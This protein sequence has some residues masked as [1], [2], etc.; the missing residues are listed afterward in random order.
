VDITRRTAIGKA[1]ASLAATGRLLAQDSGASDGQKF[2]VRLLTSSNLSVS[3]LLEQAPARPTARGAQRLGRGANVAALVAA[4]CAAESPLYKSQALIP[5][6]DEAAEAFV[7]AQNADGTLDAG[8]LASPPDT[9][10][11][12]EGL[13]ASL[14]VLR[15]LS[16]PATER[17][18]RALS[19]FLLAAGE[20]L[21][22]GGIHTPNHR[23][24]V[25]SALAR[26]NSLFPSE[27]YVKRIDEWL[28]EGID[29]DA[30]GQFAERSPNYA[31]VTVNAFVTMARLLK[32]PELL[33]PVRKHLDLTLHLMHP[34]AEIETVASRRQDQT[35]PI[36]IANFYL[37]YRYMAIVDQNPLY[38]AATRLIERMPG[39]GLIE[40]TNPVIYFMED[41]LL[42][43]ALPA[44]GE[45]PTDFTKV[46]PGTG[47]ARIRRGSVSATIYA[48]SD[49]PAGVA[50]GLAGNPTF[51]S[52]RKGRAVLQSVRMGGQFFSLGVFRGTALK[53]DGN[54]YSLQQRLEAPYYQPLPKHLRK[55]SGEYALTPAKDGRFWSKLDFTHRQMSNIQV[56]DQ[57]VT[58]VDK[59]RSFE[60]QIDIDG[61]DRVPY[62]VELAFRS[63]GEFAG[64]LR[65]I[66]LP[67]ETKALLLTEGTGRYRVGDDAIEFGPGQGDHQSLNLSGHSY[68]AHGAMLRAEGRCVY[69]TG[70]TPFKKTIVIGEA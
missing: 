23:W 50:S 30:D 48:G 14:A 25:C 67:N 40:G 56:L 18:T 10:F 55:R 41:P 44:G 13:A 46:V 29:I 52:F 34:D 19:K 26:I 54:R 11:V 65:E 33:K 66:S 7:L 8:N 3:R 16:D 47:L 20:P 24:V 4:Y 32:R 38:A 5:L 45:V 43:Q 69:L 64:S 70:Y 61:H 57:K 17:A 6:L 15:Q 68:A 59:G 36:S 28:S 63:G 37:Q 35:R 2:F 1:A 42:K 62:V 22:T 12:C 60:L 49:W 31:R 21:A 39:E 27:K 9:A 51:F 58:V 53:V